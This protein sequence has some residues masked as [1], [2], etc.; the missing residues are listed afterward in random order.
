MKRPSIEEVEREIAALDGLDLKALQNRWRELYK[1]EPPFKIRSGFLRRA[2]AYRLQELVFGGLSTK[3]RQLRSIADDARARRQPSAAGAANGS[4]EAPVSTLA[5][6]RRILSPGTRLLREWNGGT[7]I[8]DVLVD[9]FGWRGKT[10]R[11]L[12]AAA[13]A[14]TG[15][16][17]SGPKFFGL[18]GGTRGKAKKPPPADQELLAL[19]VRPL[20]AILTDHHRLP[21]AGELQPSPLLLLEVT[22]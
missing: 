2:I 20:D 13:V 14:I 16:K 22:P 19:A 9:G 6:R 10:Y 11:T 4:F 1:V 21:V 5:P 18:T 15:T 12:S 8:V 3:T 17:W 7:E